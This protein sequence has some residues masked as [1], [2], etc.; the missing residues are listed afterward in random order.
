MQCFLILYYRVTM[1]NV[2]AC[3][4]QKYRFI[5]LKLLT[6]ISVVATL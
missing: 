3:S 4:D 5:F 1:P 2:M 6:R